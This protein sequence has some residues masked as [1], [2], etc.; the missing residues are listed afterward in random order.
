MEAGGTFLT[1]GLDT[2]VSRE[3][4]EEITSTLTYLGGSQAFLGQFV[5]LFLHVVRRQLQPLQ[6]EEKSALG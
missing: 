4:K 3:Q 2:F 6:M 1:Y 5:N